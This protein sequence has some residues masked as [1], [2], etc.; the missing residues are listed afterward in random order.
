MPINAA[1]TGSLVEPYDVDIDARN[2]LA[3]AEIGRAH[4]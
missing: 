1:A 2:C 3:Y 4:V